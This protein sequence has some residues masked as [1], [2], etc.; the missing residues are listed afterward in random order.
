MLIS[1]MSPHSPKTGATTTALLLALGLG[2]MKKKVLLTHT[3]SVSDSFHTYLGLQQFEDKTSTPTQMVKLLREGAIQSDDIADYCK[4]VADNVY[5]F[6][7]NKSNFSD[8]DMLT[9]SEYLVEHSDFD[10]I[11]Y[12][13]NDYECETAKYILRKSEAIVLNFTQSVIE[14]EQFKKSMQKYS[15]MFNGKKL[16]LAC[17]KYSSIVGKDKDIP[18]KLGFKAP[19]N[20]IHYNSWLTMACNTGQLLTLYNNIRAKNSKVV[21]LNNDINRLA[22]VVTK[23]RI[24]N[25]KAKQEEKKNTTAQNAG[26]VDNAK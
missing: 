24:A 6:T 18:K 7:N 3:D 19:C 16:I 15:K 1:V 9:L 8:E 2:N 12:D 14:L 17:N 4:N 25:L 21:E 22:S 5:V 26:G 23:L 20:V 11:I 13:F 10:Y